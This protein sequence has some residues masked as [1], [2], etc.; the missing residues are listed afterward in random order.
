MDKSPKRPSSGHTN[1]Y[2]KR[3]VTMVNRNSFLSIS[4]LKLSG[5]INIMTDQ[6]FNN[7]VRD[8]NSFVD[9]FP[10][11]ADRMRAD[12]DAK[13]YDVLRSNLTDVSETLSRL[14]ADDLVAECRQ[15]LA[16]LYGAK[17]GGID[18]Y[19]VEASLESFILS[20]ST[21]SID[22]QMAMRDSSAARPSYQTQMRTATHSSMRSILAVDNA[23]MFLH[24]LRKLLADAP[25]DLHCVSSGE[26]ALRLLKNGLRPDLFLLD[27]EMPGM[28]GY[29]LARRIKMDGARGP[30]VFITANSAREYVDK[31][32]EVGA[33]GLLMKPLRAN[34]LLAKIKEFI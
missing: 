12:L 14:H 17:S 25:Y 8:V 15:Q 22:V 24:T 32:L 23:V 1:I 19:S 20:V 10:S 5:K 9:K 28:D 34:V 21:L 30:I 7:Y 4:G 26:E 3:G 18:H 27:I 2:S 13:S 31:A 6:Q 11:M 16:K 33:V 29:E